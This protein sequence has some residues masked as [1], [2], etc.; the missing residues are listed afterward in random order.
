M[1]D[2]VSQALIEAILSPAAIVDDAGRMVAVNKAWRRLAEENGGKRQGFQIGCNYLEMCR[3]ASG[4]SSLATPLIGEILAVERQ[5]ARSV[6][7]LSEFH[8]RFAARLRALEASLDLLVGRH[9]TAPR[10]R[11]WRDRS[12]RSSP[13]RPTSACWSKVPR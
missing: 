5:T 12:F 1:L 4:D 7:S 13:I 8:D 9:W 11:H 3:A 6:S 10:W 2:A